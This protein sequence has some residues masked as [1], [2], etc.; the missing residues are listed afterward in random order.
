MKTDL[1]ILKLLVKIQKMLVDNWKKTTL[2]NLK[3]QINIWGFGGWLRW[4]R[5]MNIVL[6]NNI[7]KGEVNV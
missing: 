4:F 2:L 6:I 1:F 7:M 3:S 5:R